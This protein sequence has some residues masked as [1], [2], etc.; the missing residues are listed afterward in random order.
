MSI[1]FFIVGVGRC[2]STRLY[3]LL[4]SRPEIALTNEGKIVDLLYFF[5]RYAALPESS[6][7]D[8]L[9]QEPVKLRGLLPP[10]SVPVVSSVVAAHAR[11]MLLEIYR[12][13]FP[14]K[15]FTHWGDKLPDP[16]AALAVQSLFSDTR[17]VILIRDP[18]DVLCSYRSFAKKPHVIADNSIMTRPLPLPE[19]CANYRNI[20][21]GAVRDLRPHH[22][23]HYERLVSDPVGEVKKIFAHLGIDPGSAEVV[24]TESKELFSLHATSKSPAD[25]VG[26][27]QRD[28]TKAEVLEVE[29]VLG[30]LMEVHGYARAC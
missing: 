24:S 2:G 20:Y 13:L 30:S 12:S 3:E 9:L 10:K 21:E 8:F 11:E 22:L 1:P 14:G 25:S 17:F 23:V 29:S 15:Q 6:S 7:G 26:R 16:H 28:L 4:A 5:S 18:R 19:F 27:W